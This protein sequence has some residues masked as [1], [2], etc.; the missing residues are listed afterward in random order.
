MGTN[1][2]KIQNS[3]KDSHFVRQWEKVQNK[4]YISFLS[5][6]SPQGQDE[7]FPCALRDSG[8]KGL[9]DWMGRSGSLGSCYLG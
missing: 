9:F 7:A 6:F 1:T 3:E 5:P 8:K 2:L 4:S